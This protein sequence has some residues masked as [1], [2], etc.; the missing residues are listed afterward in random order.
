MPE[1]AGLSL[2][3]TSARYVQLGLARGSNP[4]KGQGRRASFA[5]LFG[6]RLPR[7]T[8]ILYDMR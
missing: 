5:Q 4:A 2:G 1:K 3:R 7:F 8:Y 6:R